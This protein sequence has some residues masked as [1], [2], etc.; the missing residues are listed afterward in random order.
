[1]SAS[2]FELEPQG[3]FSMEP[4]RT[5]AC[6][7]LRGTRACEAGGEAVTLAFPADGT[8]APTGVKL[9]YDG[10]RVR[11][12][13]FGGAP[14]KVISRQVARV[15]GLDH[16]ARPFARVLAADRAL[17]RI[18]RKRPGFR[19][20]VAYSPYAMAGW[21]VLCHRI[22]MSQ[23]AVLERRVS[24]AAG[25]LVQIDGAPQASF[26]RPQSFLA[27]SSFPGVP[28]EKWRRLQAV[29]RAALEGDL[30]AD[31]LAAMPYAE[32][33]ERLLRIR[34]VGPWTA[35][36]VLVR[37]VGLVDA[38]AT[39]E[40]TVYGAVALAYGLPRVPSEAELERIA[41]PWR[42]FRTWVS[43]LLVSEH[44]D[45]ARELTVQPG[46]SRG[47]ARARVRPRVET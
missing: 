17:S 3:P 45:S 18:A 21:Q 28:E 27:R 19:P 8:F 32:A 33:R 41:E 24:E 46:R 12:Q 10:R 2:D 42:P 15:L 9:T 4:V 36:A 22:R 6:G 5:M 34:G 26:P 31:A 1:M 25:D 43:V 7:F 39:G 38:L 14:A 35:D 20:V 30:E 40:R 13:V 16:D 44:F 11:G 23:A 37:G 29:A 47:R